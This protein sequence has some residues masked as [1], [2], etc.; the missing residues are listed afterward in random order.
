MAT[1]Q[2]NELG[3][4]DMSD[5]VWEWC[6]DWYGNYSSS[7]QTDPKGPTSG[8]VRV[9]RGGSRDSDARDCRSSYRSCTFPDAGGNF[10]GLRLCLSE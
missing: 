4:Y 1:K 6:Q 3:L 2:P 5:N 9:N 8:A 10:K 7:T